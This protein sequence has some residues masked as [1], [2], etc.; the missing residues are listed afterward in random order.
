MEEA[1]LKWFY[2]M[3]EK[4][5]NISQEIMMLKSEELANKLGHHE[6]KFKFDLSFSIDFQ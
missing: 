6:L 4:N 2:T 3:R 5:G 1:L